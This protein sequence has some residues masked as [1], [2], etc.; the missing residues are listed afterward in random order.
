MKI[1][2]N[3]RTALLV[4]VPAFALVATVADA[5]HQWGKY[6]WAYD[7]T[8]IAKTVVDNTD[9]DWGPR[10]AIAN[11]DWNESSRIQSPL[12]GGNNGNCDFITNQIHVCND[13]YGASGWLGIASISINGNEIVAGT[14]KLNDYYFA[15]PQYNTESWKQLVTCQEIGHDY[16]LAHQNEN[17]MTDRTTSCMEYTSWPEGNEHPDQHDYD[18][19]ESIYT[20]GGGGGGGGKGGGNGGGG[21]GGPKGKPVMLPSVGNTPSDWGKPVKSL[22]NGKPFVFERDMGSYRVVTHVTWTI[23]E[24]GEQGTPRRHSGDHHFD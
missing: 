10:V 24:A 20:T 2:P 5:R 23:E 21:G 11:A 13:D 4:A 18:E 7:G 1:K 19:L 14:T 3:Y 17:F 22:P 15:Q 8:E 16:G 6:E 12:T 9:G